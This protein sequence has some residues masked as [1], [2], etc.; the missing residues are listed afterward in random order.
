MSRFV[1]VSSNVE[2]PKLERDVLERWQRD[3]T[4]AKSVEN[5]RGNEVYYFYDGPPFATGLPHYG[6]I[7][8]SY[9]KDVV[10]RYQTM[11]GHSVPR[12]FGWD[13]HGL[14]VE[15]EAEK[16]LGFKSRADI[17]AYGIGA[18]N[19][20][21]ARSVL[22][23]T[24]EWR[25]VITRLGRWVDFDN[26]Y[27]TMDLDY[28]ESVLWCFK[29][30]HDTGLVYEDGKVVAYCTRCQTSLSNFEARLDDATRPRQDP[31][32]TVRFGLVDRPG[33]ALLAWTTTPW[34]LPSNVA[35][36]VGKDIEYVAMTNDT[37]TVWLAADAASRYQKNLDGY[38]ELKR[39]AG[40]EL[41]GLRYRPLFDYFADTDPGFVVLAGD[42]VETESGTGVVHLAPAF[43][44][45]DSVLCGAHGISGPGP[46]EN[47]GT[48][49]SAVTDFAGQHVFDAN[50]N[51]LRHL[52]D[53]DLLFHRETYDH[54]YPHCWR[55][56]SPLIYRAIR[57][58]FVRVS[59]FVDRMLAANQQINWVPDHI[60]EG[61][62]GKWLANAR[63]WA[64]SRNRFW[65]CPIPVWRCQECES[66]EVIGSV[67]ELTSKTGRS[68]TDLHRPAIDEFTFACEACEGEMTR[69]PDV[70]DCW[71]ESGAMPYAQLHY[72]FSGAQDFDAA[73][74]ADFIVEYVA[75][76]RG[77]FYTLVVLS[78]ALFDKAPFTNVICH[79]VI[80]AEDGR[81]MSK[82]LKNYPDPMALV[83]KH[84]SD[85]LRI[86]LLSSAV[87]RGSDIRFSEQ[88]VRDAVR[89]YCL[90][91]WNCL[92]FFTAYASIDDFEPQGI[93]DGLS[94]LDKYLL[95]E[96]DALRVGLEACMAEYNLANAYDL[97]LN[98]V[99]TLS[100]WYVRLVRQQLWRDGMNDQKRAVLEVLYASLTMF[101]K[102]LAPFM[103]FFSEALYRG[104]G[105]PESVHLA[106][107]PQSE[108]SWRDDQLNADMRGLR[109]AVRLARRIREDHN[110]K[111]R[112][113]LPTVSIAGLSDRVV[114]D[115]LE[116]LQEELNVKEVKTLAS[117]EGLVERRI[118]LNYANLGR[119]LRGDVKKVR[120]AVE[121]GDYQLNHDANQL[122]AA[123]YEFE[124]SDFEIGYQTSDEG[125][126]VATDQGVVV[127]LDLHQP[128]ELVAEGH[129]R[130][131]NRVLQD[132]RKEGGLHYTDRI[133]LAI[134]ASDTLWQHI[135][136]HRSWLAKQLL[137]TNIRDSALPSPQ[138]QKQVSIAGETITVSLS[139]TTAT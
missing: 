85:A 79:G 111:H 26:D 57:T 18:F 127:M 41:V 89:R 135:A 24:D 65:G 138:Q 91:L 50:P 48:F 99:N 93:G 107:W 100:G 77:W 47:D 131:L 11:R 71:F 44:E 4:F 119:R 80:L 139:R 38:R 69:V 40:R 113:P 109:T 20:E 118:K 15:Y 63:D 51:I 106:D 86:A 6:H 33:E 9:I 8:T 74:P 53:A 68:V 83:E 84:G 98:Y 90:P 43:G 82:R 112:H 92:H 21:C 32:A 67:E 70:L 105:H 61:R 62:F 54:N 45:D 12:R 36:A 117:T 39:V 56:D 60:R 126:G 2:F 49:A 46:V 16:K 123:G 125:V 66:T 7:L 114:S 121:S 110:I 130:D 124:S 73:F 103:P 81:K 29:R 128:P 55:C 23:Y 42:F 95:S 28:M 27:K 30:L 58:W 25:S 22:N 108:S 101:A 72:P 116:L 97:L 5:R 1:E 122:S 37:E 94:R 102:C 96:T 75:Q 115:N 59:S 34:T 64:I 14:P 17:E 76:T 31:A 19:Q 87:V 133:E 10:P 88:P 35:L 129:V 13:C 52:K 137:A 134:E 132:L 78:T 136:N 104:L 120:A 3:D